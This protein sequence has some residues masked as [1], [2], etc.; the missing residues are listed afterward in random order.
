MQ[1][2]LRLSGG[3]DLGG[4]DALFIFVGDE[5]DHMDFDM[6]FRSIGIQPQAFGLVKIGNRG[7]CVTRTAAKLGIPCFLLDQKIF[8]DVYAV[9]Q[10]LRN[11]IRSTP[12]GNNYAGR[13]STRTS[14]IDTILKHEL[15]S[16]PNWA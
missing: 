1:R 12:V 13:T 10:T 16:P 3:T 15:L 4:K 8:S 11:L 7:D 6:S 5:E 14:I 9:P 2:V